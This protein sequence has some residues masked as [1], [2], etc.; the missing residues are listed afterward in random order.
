MA[1]HRGMAARCSMMARCIKLGF[2]WI[3][4]RVV[5]RRPLNLSP[6]LLSRATRSCRRRF[7]LCSRVRVLMPLP[8]LASCVPCGA[9]GS[10]YSPGNVER[11][12]ARAGHGAC[13][14]LWRVKDV[15]KCSPR[16]CRHLDAMCGDDEEARVRKPMTR[17]PVKP[18]MTDSEIGI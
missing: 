5:I 14:A 10:A 8:L 1:A 13:E 17:G 4:E 7:D 9:R 15:S 11:V 2:G 6:P 3:A 18:R 12:G 16:A